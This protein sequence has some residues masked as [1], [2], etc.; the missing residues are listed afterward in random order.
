MIA[1]EILTRGVEQASS[2]QNRPNACARCN[3]LASRSSYPHRPT[4]SSFVSSAASVTSS[5]RSAC[6][7]P[8]AIGYF[9]Q[10][11]G[12]K[13]GMWIAIAVTAWLLAEF[14]TRLRRM[15][16][17]SI[18]LLIVFAFAVF[19][20]A[21]T[22]LGRSVRPTLSYRRPLTDRHRSR[23]ADD[24]SYRRFLTVL[25]T[26][27]H[28]WRFRCPSPLRGLRRTDR[29]YSRLVYGLVPQLSPV[30][31]TPSFSS[32]VLRSLRWRCASTCRSERLTR[33]TDIAFWL[34]LLAA[35]LIVHSL[36]K[37]MM[38]RFETQP[39][40]GNRHYGRLSVIEFCR[41]PDRPPRDAGVRPFLRRNC[42]LDIDPSS[43]LL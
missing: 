30:A 12:G 38:P 3:A 25:L 8:G 13:L 42:L 35:P 37:E 43:G 10:Q 23:T 6:D 26:A 31:I 32:A 16:L 22:F 36:I 14:F 1:S 9:A 17:P 39:R 28:Y 11:I 27:A 29:H 15:A 4:T 34:H 41:C 20:D 24:A 21:S 7:V 40:I 19:M 18:V 2:P 5:L 33:R